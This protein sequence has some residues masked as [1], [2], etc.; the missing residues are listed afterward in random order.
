MQYFVH[1]HIQNMNNIQN[2][3]MNKVLHIL[4]FLILVGVMLAEGERLSV[5]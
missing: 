3:H 1:V 2:M 5:S 4:V